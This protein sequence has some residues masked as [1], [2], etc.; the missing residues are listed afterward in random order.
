[1]MYCALRTTSF[2]MAYSLLFNSHI[3]YYSRPTRSAALLESGSSLSRMAVLWEAD[4]KQL[5]RDA[6]S[7]L[8]CAGISKEQDKEFIFSM[9][10]RN[11]DSK[12]DMVSVSASES[13]RP[14]FTFVPI[15]RLTLLRLSF[16]AI[17]PGSDLT[18]SSAI[19]A[20]GWS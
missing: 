10:D 7:L 8:E 3:I 19:L 12:E 1:M 20:A 17:R 13:W 11:F 14:V 16:R 5:E 18:P 4:S 9:I 15:A 2:E 6:D